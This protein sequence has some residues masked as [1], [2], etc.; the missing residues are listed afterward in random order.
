MKFFPMLPAVQDSA[1]HRGGLRLQPYSHSAI[2]LLDSTRAG[3]RMEIHSM[4]SLLVALL[5][6]T[7]STVPAA[8]QNRATFSATEH[9][10]LGKLLTEGG[11]SLYLFEE[12]R[13]QGDR[14]REVESDCTDKCLDRWPIVTG[15]PPPQAGQGVEAELIGSFRRPDG[16]IQATF[17]GWPLYYFAED[18]LPGDVNGHD[19]EEFGG[20]WYLLTPS[21]WDVGGKEERKHN[22]DQRSEKDH[23]DS[24]VR[25][26]L[27]G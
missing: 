7:G 19:V 9:A 15:D 11:M 4:L 26:K 20:E 2:L 6:A 22:R 1:L 5:I 23:T 16:K 18:L 12:D 24:P 10:K 3:L 21:G 8:A 17:N 25:L 13:R 27:S 14:G